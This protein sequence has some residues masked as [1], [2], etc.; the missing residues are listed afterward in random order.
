[1]YI[2]KQTSINLNI[3]TWLKMSKDTWTFKDTEHSVMW[4]LPSCGNTI[5]LQVQT[6]V[7]IFPILEAA[8]LSP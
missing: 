3:Y 2:L 7:L 6:H 8:E 5:K 1:M 4:L